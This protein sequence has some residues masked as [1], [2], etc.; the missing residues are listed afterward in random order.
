MQLRR[1]GPHRCLRLSP[2]CSRRP[3][4]QKPRPAAPDLE[5]ATT[6]SS[7]CPRL[8]GRASP[9]RSAAAGPL[10]TPRGV[11]VFPVPAG[12]GGQRTACR[13][14]GLYPP[15]CD[16]SA[17]LPSHRRC[18]RSCPGRGAGGSC[19]PCNWFDVGREGPCP[20]PKRLTGRGWTASSAT[21]SANSPE[22]TA[23]CANTAGAGDAHHAGSD[24]HGALAKTTTGSYY[25]GLSVESVHWF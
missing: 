4:R 18:H 6:S 23:F 16:Y 17:N 25:M 10:I 20:P 1:A 9:W 8:P 15:R 7:A 11:A 13:G 5:K 2:P 14:D 21:A 19:H 3:G 24:D 12:Q 22:M